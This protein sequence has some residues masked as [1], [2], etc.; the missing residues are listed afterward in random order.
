M[1]SHSEAL[2]QAHASGE[3]SHRQIQTILLGLM[4]GMFLASLDQNIVGTAIRTIADDLNGY[5]AQ[6]WVTTAYLITS[7]ITTPL[8]GKL[9]DIY[10]RK[11]FFLAAILIFIVGSAASSF[12]TS[13]YMLAAFRA[14]QGLGAGGL[15]SLSL[16]IIGDIVPPRERAKYQGYFL[17]VFG[18]SSVL[19]PIIG[20]F[21]ASASSI[22]YISGWRWVFLV[23]V[24][25]GIVAMLVVTATLHLHHE[26]RDA[27]IDWW[28]A[29]ALVVALVPL[30]TVAEQGRT[31]GWGNGKSIAAYAIGLIGIVGFILIEKWMGEDALIPLRIFRSRTMSIAISGS[32]VVG[33]GMFGGLMVVPQYLQIVHGADPTQSGFMMVPMVVGIMIASVVSGQLISRTGRIKIYPII[34]ISLMVISLLLLSRIGAD[35]DIRLVM[36]EMFLLGAG[37]GN[38]MQPLTL[39]VQAAASPR[40]I[41]MSTS[42]ATFSRQIGGTLGVAV[43]LSV[44]FNQLPGAV[45]T[46]FTTASQDPKF[47]AALKDP[48]LLAN[49]INA[50]FARAVASHNLSIFS[51]NDTSIIS[52]LAPVFAHPFKVG[53]SVSMDTVFL[54]GALVSVVGVLILAFL[55]NIE[56][57][58]K[59]AAAQ[60]AEEKVAALD[61]D[62]EPFVR[63]RHSPTDDLVDAAAA[64]AAGHTLMELDGV[65]AAPRHAAMHAELD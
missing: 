45:G 14:F 43:F 34:G 11:K 60:L 48:N 53:F 29:T 58:S 42:A 55:P 22:L 12:S 9:S 30:L 40:E 19:G 27:R 7:T 59:S 8:Y 1:S 35:T 54:M 39:A 2:K 49:P 46:A 64:E 62:G 18:T 28:G 38:T 50:Q 4:L 33:A 32:F 47:I 24:P 16:A 31:W 23:N 3:L 17:A 15:F 21:F 52:Q 61:D 36:A 65:R 13:M 63:P 57:S 56:L 44:L 10:G 37:L 51:L 5:S 25:I 26:R 41:G 6:A 20:G